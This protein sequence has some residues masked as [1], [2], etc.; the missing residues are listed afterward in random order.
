MTL[1]KKSKIPTQH[2][3]A[4]YQARSYLKEGPKKTSLGG[5]LRHLKFGQNDLLVAAME[6][7]DIWSPASRPWSSP[8]PRGKYKAKLIEFLPTESFEQQK[9]E[10]LRLQ[11]GSTIRPRWKGW[12]SKLKSEQI[13]PTFFKFVQCMLY[14]CFTVCQN[15]YGSSKWLQRWSPGLGLPSPGRCL[16]NFNCRRGPPRLV[17]LDPPF[18]YDLAWY[19]GVTCWVGIFDFLQS[20]TCETP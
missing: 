7:K 3:T 2:V 4:R 18:G 20:V 13:N 1:C 5:P 14:S 6:M 15:P 11:T 19:L 12:E 17:I 16:S 10:G 9:V 8:P